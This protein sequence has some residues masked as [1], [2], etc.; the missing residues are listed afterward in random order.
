M[1]RQS[2]I[3]GLKCYEYSQKWTGSPRFCEEHKSHEE[4][5]NEKEEVEKEE[6]KDDEEEDSD[7]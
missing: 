6:D 3:E 5:E 4:E 1:T 2:Y 7:D